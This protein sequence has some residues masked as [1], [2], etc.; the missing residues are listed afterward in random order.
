MN[1]FLPKN[2]SA[3]E[4]WFSAKFGEIYFSN[5]VKFGQKSCPKNNLA[6]L[7]YSLE[8]TVYYILLHQ[9]YHI[10]QYIRVA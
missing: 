6:E 4:K 10:G 3:K 1:V 9:M 5:F 8:H 2:I 7:F